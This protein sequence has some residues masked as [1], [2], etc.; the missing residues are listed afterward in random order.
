LYDRATAFL[1]LH[2]NH[3][4]FYSK[5]G[6]CVPITKS[7]QPGPA[8]GLFSNKNRPIRSSDTDTIA[9]IYG[10]LAGAHYGYQSLLEHWLSM[11]MLKRS[12]KS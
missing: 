4:M 11:S 7:D 8:H 6:P 10:Q 1:L 3:Y 5:I 9:D 2:H 12:W